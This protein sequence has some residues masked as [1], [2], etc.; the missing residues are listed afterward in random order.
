M[1]QHR[2][3]TTSNQ[4]YIP[5]E[6]FLTVLHYCKQYPLWCAELATDPDSSKAITYDK[7][8]VQTSNQYNPTEEIAMRRAEIARKKR[9][10][11]EVVHEAATG[12][13][14]WMILGV[15]YGM[16]FYQLEQRGI[17]CGKN[18]YYDKRRRIY[19]EISRRI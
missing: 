1:S 15:C 13:Y 6:E 9:M 18:Y 3:L 5:K 19:Y 8:R 4:Y 16:T 2:I 17:P 7:E 10:L 12:L 14:D 11:E